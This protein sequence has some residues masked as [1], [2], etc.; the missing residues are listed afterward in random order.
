VSLKDRI[1]EDLKDALR[2]RDSDRLK[3][4]RMVKA[5]IRNAEIDKHEDLDDQ[6]VLGVLVKAAKQRRESIEAYRE[7]GRDDLVSVEQGELDIIE[8]YLPQQMTEEEL[9]EYVAKAIEEM[10]AQGPKDMGRVMKHLMAELKGQADGRMVNSI[11]R[12]FLMG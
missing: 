4:L 10:G 1:Q 2:Q 8:S 12:E 5:S 9:R 11:V 3:V 7:G 6:E